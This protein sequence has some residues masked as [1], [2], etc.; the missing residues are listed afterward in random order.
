MKTLILAC[1]C[2]VL[3]SCQSNT[4][5]QASLKT[6][7]D[8]VSY[9]LGMD[10]GKNIK[11]QKL[12]VDAAVIAQGLKDY[13]DSTKLQ[14]TPEQ[15]QQVITAWRTQLMKQQ[16]AEA[17]AAGEKA[18]AEGEKFLA[19]NKTKEG[20]KTTASGLQYKIDKLG[21]GAKPT[22]E[23][24]VTVNYR[25]TLLDGTEFDNSYKRG[26]PATFPLNGVISGWT[27]GL[28]L[29]PVGSKFTFYIPSEM[30][31]GERG[32]GQQIPPYSVLVFEV[33]L[34]EIKK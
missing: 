15:Q 22:A 3:M 4:Q 26:E 34:L 30:A 16:Q 17:A 5:Q 19:D 25:G 9:S 11:S 7:K 6:N 31:Y 12:D 18:K 33:E 2:L 14:L 21:T 8:S 27:E 28:Q 32:A 10:I 29:M 23:Q 13:F 20:V 1:A 24:T